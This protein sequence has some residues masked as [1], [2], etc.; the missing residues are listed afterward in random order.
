MARDLGSNMPPTGI[1]RYAVMNA[2][3]RMDGN[4]RVV[5][6]HAHIAL[7]AKPGLVTS[8]SEAI[9]YMHAYALACIC[10]VCQESLGYSILYQKASIASRDGTHEATHMG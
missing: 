10:V 4:I 8:R 6:R 1:E 2:V 9:V 5:S 7:Q 3:T